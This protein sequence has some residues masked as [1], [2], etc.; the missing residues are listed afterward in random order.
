M[1]YIGKNLKN[2]RKRNGITQEV[3]AE[4]LNVTRQAVSNWENGKTRPDIDMLC[5][6]SA[7]LETDVNEILYG[8]KK[9]A[10]GYRRF[11]K[12]YVICTCIAVTVILLGIILRIALLPRLVEQVGEGFNI[13]GLVLYSLLVTPLVMLSVG[14]VLP[15]FLSMYYDICLNKKQRMVFLIIAALFLL[16]SLLK[17][18]PNIVFFAGNKIFYSFSYAFI[19]VPVQQVLYGKNFAIISMFIPAICGACAFLGLNKK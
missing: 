14:C 6:I 18:L 9:Q 15:S 2:I 16:L 4:K 3:L 12:K 1:N 7:A 13:G 5:E 11:Q 19:P 10:E 8:E 17:V